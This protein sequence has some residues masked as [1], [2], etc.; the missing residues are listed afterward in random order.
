MDD[1]DKSWL[2]DKCP[3][4]HICGR[5]Y[6]H[7]NGC[8]KSYS[9]PPNPYYDS[10]II[11]D[12]GRGDE[13]KNAK[14]E[15]RNVNSLMEYIVRQS[16]L[17][18]QTKLLKFQESVYDG[19]TYMTTQLIE[20]TVEL[21]QEIDQ[22]G[23][24]IHDLEAHLNKKIEASD[25]QS[26]IVVDDDQLVEQKEEFQ[27]FNYT[28]FLKI[29]VKKEYKNENVV[30]NV[31]LELRL[32]ESHSKH[33][34]IKSEL[35]DE[36]IDEEQGPYILKFFSPCRQSDIFHLRAKKRKMRH[37]LFGS[38]IFIPSPLERSRKIDAMLGIRESLSTQ[39]FGAKEHV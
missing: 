39:E 34:S 27:P 31:A 10:S 20:G 1:C 5:Q 32:L 12:V 18:E 33:F 29:E 17:Q 4:C 2:G 3:L 9:L 7:R 36:C 28:L 22:F 19:L 25:V 13:V 16:W 24:Y 30:N 38:F 14:Q 37:I 21:T 15:A 6:I 23:S 11:C 8:P 35:M 26:P